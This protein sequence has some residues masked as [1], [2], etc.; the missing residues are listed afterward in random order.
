M[1]RVGRH[2]QRADILSCIH[3][4]ENI[5]SAE[6]CDGFSVNGEI[7][8]GEGG[9]FKVKK[10]GSYSK[11]GTNGKFQGETISRIKVQVR[12][13]SASDAPS[14]PARWV[15]VSLSDGGRLVRRV[16]GA[17]PAGCR[18]GREGRR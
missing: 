13:A 6:E 18:C 17:R 2:Q 5:L 7:L 4:S 10:E 14:S 12:S 15:V 11:G 8:K 16:A 1:K 3:P 9:M